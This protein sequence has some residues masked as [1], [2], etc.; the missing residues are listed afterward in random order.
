MKENEQ[1]KNLIK[2]IRKTQKILSKLDSFYNE[3]QKN[4]LPLLGKKKASAIII[5]E[6]MVNFY[7]CVETL[8]LRISQF[9]ENTLQKD[10]WHTD[11]LHKMTLGVLDTRMPV[12]SDETYSILLE[13]MK[14]RH[15]KR[16]YFEFNYDWDRIEFLQK[17]YNQVKPLLEKDLRQFID[18]LNKVR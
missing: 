10:K 5:S 2:E 14:F 13:F 7:T 18:F 6:I 3:F 9:F 12:I 8:F 15:F 11:L 17:K 16:Y 4:E 1:V